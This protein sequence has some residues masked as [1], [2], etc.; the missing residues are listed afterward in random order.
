MPTSEYILINNRLEDGIK[1][2]AMGLVEDEYL[3]AANHTTITP[4]STTTNPMSSTHKVPA[5]SLP[6]PK[7]IE[8]RPKTSIH[9]CV[10]AG[11]VSGLRWSGTQTRHL[12]NE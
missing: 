10:T 12:D 9:S 11:E 7:H 5:L 6:S 2:T 3:R 8:I 1:A 4:F